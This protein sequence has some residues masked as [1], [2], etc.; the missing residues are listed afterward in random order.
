MLHLCS[1]SKVLNTSHP[2]ELVVTY[3]V[4]SR[5]GSKPH[6]FCS[7]LTCFMRI[8]LSL[9][10]FAIQYH[11]KRLNA[12]DRLVVYKTK[13]PLSTYN[14]VWYMNGNVPGELRNRVD[15]SLVT[16]RLEDKMR[17]ILG[18]VEHDSTIAK[19]GELSQRIPVA[20]LGPL[21]IA[22]LGPLVLGV[23]AGLLWEWISRCSV[24]N[25]MRKFELVE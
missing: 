4:S 11:L 7:V 13:R 10:Q 18:R 16:L 12:C 25:R 17:A 19:C 5:E 3:D 9:L 2:A 14:G 15:R 23:I 8:V 1:V 20:F 22:V 6:F 21:F 24:R